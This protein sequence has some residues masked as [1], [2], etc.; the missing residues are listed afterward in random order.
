MPV[1]ADFVDAEG[2]LTL[3]ALEDG[4]LGTILCCLTVMPLHN[5]NEDM[6]TGA[7]ELHAQ[8]QVHFIAGT[9]VLQKRGRR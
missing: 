1:G 9:K 3:V 2:G 8:M 5:Q 4:G 6:K 7:S